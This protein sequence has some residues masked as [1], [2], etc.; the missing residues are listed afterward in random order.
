[1]LPPKAMTMAWRSMTK[2]HRSVW[3]EEQAGVNSDDGKNGVLFLKTRT[4]FKLI[5]RV[6]S[7]TS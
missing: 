3:T 5:L 6:V 1:M 2:M 4:I 7:W